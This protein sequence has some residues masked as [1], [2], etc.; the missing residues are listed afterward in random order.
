MELVAGLAV[1]LVAGAW[2]DRL[3]RRPV[4]IW[5]DLGRAA[6]LGLVPLAWLGGW[7]SL[8][9]LLLV[10]L[11]TAVLTTFFDAADNAFLPTIV[12]RAD[13]VRANGA[14][15]ASSSVSEFA[16]FG[17][18]GFLVQILTAPIAIFADALSFLVSAILLGTIRVKE[19]PPPAKADREP[20]L[21]EIA[22]G[23]RLVARNP[24]LRATTLAT[25][26]TASMW[27]VFGAL[28]FLFAVEELHLDPAAIGVVAAV[29][30]VSS[31][32]GALL[33]PRLTR[34]FGIGR[35]LFGGVVVG[36]LGNYFIPFAPVG[37]PLIT[38]LF[39]VGQQLVTDPSMTAFDI[40]DTSIRQS[41]VHDR[42]LGR[43]N[44]TIR[45]AVLTAQLIATLLA[46]LLAVQVG[47]REMLV[48]GPAVGL[49][50]AVAIWFSPVRRLKRIEDLAPVD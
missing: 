6:L 2:V 17:S 45:V 39:L 37:A 32:F 20:V 46:G 27:G 50:G 15:S 9:L 48:I 41:I 47:L 36:M 49:L 31:L 44:A 14:L 10:T 1:G 11:L 21:S 38:M 4:M 34:R 16:A 40:T 19:A 35:V 25:M 5:A 23:L 42:Q 28:Y 26:A 7:L 24:I 30:G 13:L 33:T 22:I 12:P 8:P 43:V 3:R 18:A 29:G